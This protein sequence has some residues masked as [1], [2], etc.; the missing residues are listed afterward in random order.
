MRNETRRSRT[1]RFYA[2]L[3]LFTATL[4]LLWF[5]PAPIHGDT[6][7][8]KVYRHP[9]LD[10]EFE[11]P[12]GWKNV[13]HPEDGLIYEMKDPESGLRVMLWLT[14][15]EQDCP[16]YLEKMA[17]MKGYRAETPAERRIGTSDGWIIETVGD[18]YGKLSQVMLAG[19][20]RPG[21]YP[22]ENALYI[23]QIWCPEEEYAQLKRQMT[24]ILASVKV[25]SGE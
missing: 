11:A 3:I 23:V 15:T 9:T 1:K 25:M 6:A 20:A 13:R 8:T 2:A 10:F 5:G 12:S 14:T 17:D 18:I 24:E 21:G 22:E 4:V 19:V 7:A 16:G